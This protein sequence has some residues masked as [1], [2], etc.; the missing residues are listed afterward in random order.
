MTNP[1]A[2]AIPSDTVGTEPH[3][4][5]WAAAL[6]EGF[7]LPLLI[8]VAAV[9]FYEL[10]FFIH[11]EQVHVRIHD[12]LDWIPV[13][14]AK[15]FPEFAN[16]G[17]TLPFLL[18]G[19]P[20]SAL[21]ADS[22]VILLMY[23]FLPPAAA[24]VFNDFVARLVGFV[25][26]FLL[27]RRLNFGPIG[28]AL[29]IAVA[30]SWLPLYY[31][32]WQGI[33]ITGMP[34]LLFLAWR[35][36]E[37]RVPS[38]LASFGALAF[39]LFFPFYSRIGFVGMYLVLLFGAVW[40]IRLVVYRDFSIN[41][42]LTVVLLG[43]GYFLA[44]WELFTNQ[45]RE[46]PI[47]W[48]REEVDRLKVFFFNNREDPIGAILYRGFRYIY[49]S[50]YH[51]HA[52]PRVAWLSLAVFMGVLVAKKSL[53]FTGLAALQPVH[54][55]RKKRLLRWVTACVGTMAAFGGVLI[56]Y[57]LMMTSEEIL[58]TLRTL[59]LVSSVQLDR[60]YFFLPV[61]F[62]ILLFASVSGL[63]LEGNLW[64]LAAA[65]LVALSLVHNLKT[66][67]WMDVR[68]E[69]NFAQYKSEAAFD[70]LEETMGRERSAGKIACLAFHPAIA[71]LNRFATVGGYWPLYPLDY[72][73]RF[74]EAMAGEL[75]K[76]EELRITFDFW[77]HRCY[78]LT[79]ELSLHDNYYLGKKN[80]PVLRD[81]DLNVAALKELGADHLVS[82]V[83]IGNAASLGLEFLGEIDDPGSAIRLFV[84]RLPS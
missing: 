10:P 14:A 23:R 84:Y 74:R 53:G 42:T 45:L 80:G 12:N 36:H 11:G 60:V 44:N 31:I 26:A 71:H 30:F 18:G 47:V 64:K 51:A 52:N 1:V 79:S 70:R 4:S 73:H 55:P 77:A 3:R 20:K 9:A 21:A 22:N 59:P 34:L 81:F 5:R 82:A 65:G 32:S 16:D 27:Y 2:T 69:P 19:L 68:G 49:E 66:A 39:F 41:L 83:E 13:Y 50:H 28:L 46:V 40:F 72:K 67:D 62:S 33:S 48:H 29:G 15:N 61:L 7:L 17:D 6:Q 63:W 54:D 37:E 75:E 58:S 8:G 35:L 25:G 78:L 43:F 24:Y 76:S 38:N 56:L 57:R